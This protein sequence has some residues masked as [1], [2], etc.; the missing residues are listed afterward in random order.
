[1]SVEQKSLLFLAAPSASHKKDPK[2]P[3]PKENSRLFSRK[4][5]IRY[6]LQV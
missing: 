5:A 4:V 3:S 2:K 6:L 1:M